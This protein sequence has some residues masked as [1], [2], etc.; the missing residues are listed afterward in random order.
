MK[1]SWCL[2]ASST[3]ET[4]KDLTWFYGSRWGIEMV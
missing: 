2:A 1:Q 3:D 4:A